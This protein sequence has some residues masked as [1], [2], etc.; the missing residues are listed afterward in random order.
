MQIPSVQFEPYQLEEPMV[1]GILN[2][3]S[4]NTILPYSAL[5]LYTEGSI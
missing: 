3:Y 1:E 2:Y 5:E 4:A